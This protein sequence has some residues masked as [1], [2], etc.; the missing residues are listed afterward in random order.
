MLKIDH[1]HLGESCTSCMSFEQ[2]RVISKA[3]TRGIISLRLEK[4]ERYKSKCSF[5]DLSSSLSSSSPLRASDLLFCPPIFTC[6]MSNDIEGFFRDC[7]G[8]TNGVESIVQQF[9][10]R[11]RDSSGAC[12]PAAFSSAGISIQV[13]YIIFI[14]R[15]LIWMLKKLELVWCGLLQDNY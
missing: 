14:H 6:D 13:S 10:D 7:P 2:Y 8:E 5:Q 11:Q 1:G 4:R 9:I 15:P 3:E 12:S